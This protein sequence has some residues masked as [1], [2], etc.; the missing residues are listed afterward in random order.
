M[1]FSKTSNLTRPA[2]L[3]NFDTFL[4]SKKPEKPEQNLEMD[5]GGGSADRLHTQWAES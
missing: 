4:N 3:L 1:S 5:G 2:G